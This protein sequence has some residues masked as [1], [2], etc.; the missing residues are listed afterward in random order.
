MCKA[1]AE[2]GRNLVRQASL[3]NPTVTDYPAGPADS[4][5][6]PDR[7]PVPESPARP[8]DGTEAVPGERLAD[9]RP[10]LL[11]ERAAALVE[12]VLTSGFPTQLLIAWTLVRFGLP[13]RTADGGLAPTFVFTMSL[14][15]AVLVTALIV[16]FLRDGGERVGQVLLG[17]RSL[18]PE[19]ALGV[20]LVPLIFLVLVLVMS[21]VL[22][23]APTLH[24]VAVNPL[25]AM[26]QTPRDTLIFA[27]VVM[28]A[29][30][31]REEIQRAFVI[32]RFDQ[33][34]GG[35]LVGVLAYSLAFGLGHVQQGNDAIVATAALGAIWGIVYLVRRSIV[36]PV[37]SHAAFNL[38][39]L[40]KFAALR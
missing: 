5:D 21:A 3:Y 7:E 18:L 28:I 37:V 40:L 22:T 19:L 16:Y 34:L 25:G 2:L 12:V 8:V 20:A 17:R 36:A 24:N 11:R 30:G 33:Y 26:M 1:E 14:I 4:A 39:Q 23:L 6:S 13:M 15:D 10:V 38:I 27:V 35:G 31:V 29:G 32:H 9:D